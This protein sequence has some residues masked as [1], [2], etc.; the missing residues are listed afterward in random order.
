MM[1]RD[2]RLPRQHSEIDAAISQEIENIYNISDAAWA[3]LA[4]SVEIGTFELRD[5]CCKGTLT[6][7]GYVG[8]HLRH[9]RRGVWSLLPGDRKANVL[10]FRAGPKPANESQ[11]LFKVWTLMQLQEVDL[12]LEGLEFLS[13]AHNVASGLMRAH[14]A[15]GSATLQSRSQLIQ[16]QP[17]VSQ[18]PL[19]KRLAEKQ[20]QLARVDAKQPAKFTGRQLYERELTCE[21]QEQRLR[22]KQVPDDIHI[23]IMARHGARWAALSGNRKRE[24]EEKAVDE[25]GA[26]IASN[27]GRRLR[28]S[29]DI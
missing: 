12:V 22:G 19:E 21:A 13:K 17:L 8:M 28:L 6:A 11:T 24:Y 25:R 16:F 4:A 1:M 29:K 10:A 2:D 3:F 14:R 20:Q 18:A 15:Y 5:A 9:A 27:A 23:E 26:S 7:A